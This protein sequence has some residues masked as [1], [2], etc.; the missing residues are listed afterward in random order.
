[1]SRQQRDK[2]IL[3]PFPTIGD[4]KDVK[5]PFVGKLDRTNP[6]HAKSKEQWPGWAVKLAQEVEARACLPGL[7][8]GE[9]NLRSSSSFPLFLAPLHP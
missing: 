5:Y 3:V 7:P 9:L 2:W 6:T 4:Q 8:I 1:M